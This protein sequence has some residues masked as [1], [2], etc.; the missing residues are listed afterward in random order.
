MTDIRHDWEK[1][2]ITALFNL[3]FNDLLFMAQ[4]VHRPGLGD[5]QP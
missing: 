3:P 5:G 1:G 4:G 2:E